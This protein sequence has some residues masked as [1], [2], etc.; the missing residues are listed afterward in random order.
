MGVVLVADDEQPVR[1]VASW[2]LESHGH[3]VLTASNGVEAV[4]LFRSSPDSIDLV[5]TD[6]KMPVM[7]GHEVVRLIRETRSNAKIICTSGFTDE[8]CP[9]DVVFLPKPFTPNELRATVN[10]LLGNSRGP[11]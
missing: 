11:D 8:H 3:Q 5:V 6:L 9:P 10:R 7:D 4:A 2:T 1:S